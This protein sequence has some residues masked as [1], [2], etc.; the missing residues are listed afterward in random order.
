MRAVV[1]REIRNRDA[2]SI[3]EVPDPVPGPG[4]VR[5]DVRACGI[6]FTDLLSLDGRYQ[7]N[8]PPPFTPG[9]D[10]AGVVRSIGEGVQGLAPGQRV[11]AH[12]TYGGLAERVI[13]PEPRCLPVPDA[14]DFPSAAG[15][16]LVYL[17]AYFALRVRGGLEPG[18]TVLVNGASGGVGLA[19]VSLARALGAGRVL[20]GLTTPAKGQAATD[21]G[22]D[23]LIDL[24]A[25]PL[26]DTLRR[27]VHDANRGSGADLVVDLL[28]GQHFGAALR[29]LATYGRIVVTGFAG[30]EIPTVRTNYLL[31]KN[32]AV[33]GMTLQTFLDGHSPL[34]AEAQRFIFEHA[35]A[36]DL[37]PHVTATY[38]FERYM[39][40]IR[41]IED[42]RVI[43]KSV[44]V[45][46]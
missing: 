37:D 14:I 31:L 35:L 13:C 7:N 29:A 30:G 20:A 42:R 40:A 25:A 45:F 18:Q 19:S 5:V 44:V 21:A 1:I 16:G 41:R 11:L 15:F 22:A 9:K 27:Q 32:I 39:E 12:V 46:D 8:P 4:E 38:R 3:E 6:N 26:E 24:S 2:V 43:G 36:G 33:V 23:H 10:A 34:L 28:G 17:T